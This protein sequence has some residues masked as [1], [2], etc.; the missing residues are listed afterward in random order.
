MDLSIR[1]ASSQDQAEWLGLW[2]D[3]LAFYN[4]DLADEVTA[5]TWERI[6]DPASRVSAR[7]AVLHGQ[8]VGFAIHHFHDSTWVK[9]P[10]CYL[11]DLFINANIRGKG[12]GRALIDD[13]ISICKD[14]GWSRLYWH[15]N[16][17]NAQARKLYDSY[18]RSDGHIRYRIKF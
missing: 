12:I 11:E 3:Y 17:D 9:T 5:H 6:I 10:D 16:E 7:L 18:V 14:K 4:V 13:L 1:D 8:V 2:S 15:T